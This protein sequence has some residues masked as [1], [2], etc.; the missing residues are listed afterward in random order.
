M[1]SLNNLLIKEKSGRLQ[2]A[3]LRWNLYLLVKQNCDISMESFVIVHYET[4]GITFQNR[5]SD[6]FLG[7]EERYPHSKNH[8]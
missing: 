5:S 4:T 6:S 1:F 3:Q 7:F 2:V 8:I